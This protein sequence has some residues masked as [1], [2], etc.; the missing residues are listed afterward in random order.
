M[1][2]I[3]TINEIISNTTPFQPKVQYGTQPIDENNT[4]VLY[5]DI[6]LDSNKGDMNYLI[7]TIEDGENYIDFMNDG[8]TIY[9][10]I[11][12]YETKQDKKYECISTTVMVQIDSLEL[13]GLRTLSG[14]KKYYR[15]R[16]TG[17][18]V[19]EKIQQQPA[20]NPDYNPYTISLGTAF[21]GLGCP[22]Y[23]L[24]KLAV[25]H[26]SEFVIDND[27][28]CRQTLTNN[29]NPKL[30]LE[31]I[32]KVDTTKLPQSDLYIWGSPCQN[33]SMAATSSSKGRLGLKGKTG[34]LFWDGFRILKETQPKYS[35]F[36]N[37][38]GLTNHDGGNTFKVIMEAF[39][40]L[41]DYNIFHKVINP[42]DIGGNTNRERIFI[43][44]VRNDVKI[45]FSFPKNVENNTS[46]IK[47]C[48]ID[49][50]Y[51]YIDPSMLE[52][53]KTPVEKQRGKLKKDYLWTGTKREADKRVF[54]I[55]YP[56]PTITRSGHLLVNDTK[57]VRKLSVIELKKVQGFG[58]DLSFEGL[59]NTQIKSQLGNTMEVKT[60]EKLISEIIRID[61]LHRKYLKISNNP[62]NNTKQ[63]QKDKI[64]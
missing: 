42:I 14:G 35:I 45:P 17:I 57:G 4:T 29:Y 30:V 56:A 12:L 7:L 23:V 46:C 21:S 18:Q 54:N 38:K 32:T 43:V 49:G 52:S 58:D 2:S 13:K 55:N 41:G 22:E 33:F 47:D 5:G 6:T 64:S 9:Y 1:N 63:L 27:K 50:D 11:N 8:G 26:T 31:D 60:M 51:D 39:K 37:V 10:Q 16:I 61:K 28:Y 62:I 53:F 40:S 25:N 48:L 36:E 3:Q 44:L 59:S 34:V 20:N 19:D 24:N 15:H